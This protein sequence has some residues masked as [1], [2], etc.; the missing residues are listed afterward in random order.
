MAEICADQDLEADAAEVWRRF[1]RAAYLQRA[2]THD[3]PVYHTYEE[4]WANQFER[5]FKLLRLPGDP[6]KASLHLKERLTGAP[7]FDDAL[8]AIQALE[9]HY[10]I[11]VLSNA[12]NDF[13]HACLERNGLKFDTV[14]SSED[15]GAIKPHPDIFHFLARKLNEPVGRILYAGD[16]PIP[17]VLGPSRAGMKVAWVNRTGMRKPRKVPYPDI[18]VESLTDLV[19]ILTPTRD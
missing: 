16:N 3:E 14:I 5:V 2:E 17:D 4:A 19:R 8:A 7:A 18:R 15:A 1:L 6:E 9:E 10:P 12:D 11:A 13:L